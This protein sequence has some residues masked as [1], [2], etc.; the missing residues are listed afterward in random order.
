MIE[1][2]YY[3]LNHPRPLAPWELKFLG[4]MLAQGAVLR[5]CCPNRKNANNITWE[6]TIEI[7]PLRIIRTVSDVP[8]G[9]VRLKDFQ[10][11][12]KSKWIRQ[13]L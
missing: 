7:T 3:V 6:F 9:S 10:Q 2:T 4:I 8:E 13:P 5:Y 1:K 11:Y 12:K